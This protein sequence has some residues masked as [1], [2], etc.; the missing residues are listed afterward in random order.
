MTRPRS[1]GARKITESQKARENRSIAA[2]KSAAPQEEVE[3]I[4]SDEDESSDEDIPPPFRKAKQKMDISEWTYQLIYTAH[5]D[6]KCVLSKVRPY[7]MGLANLRIIDREMGAAMQAETDKLQVVFARESGVAAL[8]GLGLSKAEMLI[9]T[10]DDWWDV[11]ENLKDYFDKDIKRVRVEYKVLYVSQ[12]PEKD[13][14]VE[15]I[16]SPTTTN[17]AAGKRSAKNIP[18]SIKKRRVH[19]PSSLLTAD[20]N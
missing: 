9:E 10:Q 5:C 11:E 14:D 2:G 16:E 15:E 3:I 4:P 19:T 13:S 6:K 18:T 12:K 1:Q 17:K 20:Y 7:K 8:Y